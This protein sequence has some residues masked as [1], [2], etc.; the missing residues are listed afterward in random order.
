M[1][2]VTL[3]LNVR[4]TSFLLN[5]Q[6]T[7]FLKKWELKFKKI[8]KMNRRRNLLHLWMAKLAS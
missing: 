4:N 5:Y 2:L 7:I 3:R 8:K 1:K 6:K